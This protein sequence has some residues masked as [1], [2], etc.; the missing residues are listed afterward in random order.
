MLWL[1]AAVAAYFI[2]AVVFLVDKYLLVS[3][4]PNPKVFS[5][6]V[7]MLGIT[8]LVLIPF[9][10]FQIPELPQIGLSLLAGAL[11][12][13]G[14]FWFYKALKL[15]ES[16]R[17]IPAIGGILPIFTFL[18]I[19]VLSGGKE[20]LRS[21]GL[22]AFILTILGSVLINYDSS[23]KLSFKSLC[24]SVVAA[25]LFALSF[26][27]TKYVYLA[28]PFWSGFIWMKIGSAL[29][30][31]VFFFSSEVREELFKNKADSQKK[32]GAIFLLGQAAGAGA[33]VL[34]N[35]SIALAPLAYVAVINALQGSQYAFLL[36]LT[37]FLSIK[38]PQILKEEIVGKV[39]LQKIIAILIIGAGLA[40]LAFK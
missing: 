8:A 27:L 9:V 18:L 38:F 40:I 10:D 6:L 36:I 7:G 13:Y 26:V 24:L 28:Q 25:F 23:K 29:M 30:G 35:W 5:F 3:S 17:V 32:T 34:Q 19:L 31:A 33:N 39:V 37:I 12:V 2:L 4:I 15:F 21:W 20:T 22:I 11:F 16:S 14:L 1:I